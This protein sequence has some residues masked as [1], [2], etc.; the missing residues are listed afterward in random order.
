MIKFTL[1]EEE[2]NTLQAKEIIC[3]CFSN[4]ANTALKNPSLNLEIYQEIKKDYIEFNTDFNLEKQKLVYKYSQGKRYSR[5][6]INYYNRE[7][8]FYE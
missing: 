6:E 7:I 3:N 1:T 5:F 8:I 2:I 4:F